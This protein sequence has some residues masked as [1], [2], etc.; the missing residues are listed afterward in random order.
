MGKKTL[1]HPISLHV[2]R[3]AAE[4]C[5]WQFGK[6]TQKW[7]DAE[8]WSARYDAVIEKMPF[9]PE[10][11]YHS[12]IQQYMQDCFPDGVKIHWLHQLKNGKWACQLQVDFPHKEIK[13]RV[14][15]QVKDDIP[16]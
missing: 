15:P 16:F 12:S 14:L 1:F 4:F 11:Y 2:I 9:D 6:I 5:D 8:K 3:G 10:K 13:P 7:S